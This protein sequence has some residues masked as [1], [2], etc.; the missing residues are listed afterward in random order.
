MI[1]RGLAFGGKGEDG[2]GMHI[3]EVRGRK[4]GQ[5]YQ[6]PGAVAAVDGRHYIV[7]LWGESQW[8]RNLRA[9]GEAQLRSE[10][11]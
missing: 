10:V 1:Q 7:S 9:G 8:A 2:T 3:L 6:R 11:A 5:W 4:T